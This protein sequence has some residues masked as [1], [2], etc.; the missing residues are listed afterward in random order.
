MPDRP[1]NVLRKSGPLFFAGL[2]LWGATTFADELPDSVRERALQELRV[3]DRGPAAKSSPQRTRPSSAATEAASSPAKSSRKEE[4]RATP[5]FAQPAS[6]PA[7]VTESSPRITASPVHR[8]VNPPETESE[9]TPTIRPARPTIVRPPIRS[10]PVKSNPW[11][12]LASP[13]REANASATPTGDSDLTGSLQ[14]DETAETPTASSFAEVISDQPAPTAEPTN[15]FDATTESN[16]WRPTVSAPAEKTVTPTGQSPKAKVASPEMEKAPVGGRQQNSVATTATAQSASSKRAKAEEIGV[17]RPVSVLD[18]LAN[19]T[20]DSTA[21]DRT[22]KTAQKPASAQNLLPPASTSQSE[23]EHRSST[24]VANGLP[25]SIP[26]DDPS[27]H[28]L[29]S[30]SESDARLTTPPSGDVANHQ[31]PASEQQKLDAR[32]GRDGFMGF[33][34]VTLR[35][36]KT[37]VD[38]SP[39]FTSTFGGE[40]FEFAS[41]DAKAAFDADPL[42]YSPANGGRDIVL[43]AGRI[44]VPGSLQ[45]ATY[46]KNK[47]YLFRSEQT[48][49]LFE[50]DPARYVVEDEPQ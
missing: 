41:A 17:D 36:H 49:R 48:C 50:A 28:P 1:E 43:A 20:G 4:T 33:C 24:V 39:E 23:A 16:D 37:L 25:R 14:R 12:E 44:E 27:E 21:S 42:R 11:A 22:I 8:A 9:A 30:I 18:F 35:D 38:G 10:G 5:A 32:N 26:Q 15:P 7:R 29:E 46:Y 2:C 34:P 19:N 45:H 40:R 6:A 47:L 3:L 13:E 31:T